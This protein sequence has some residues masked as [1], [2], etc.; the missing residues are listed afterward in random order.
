LRICDFGSARIVANRDTGRCSDECGISP[1]FSP[2]E[3]V[4][5]LAGLQ[6]HGS[7]GESFNTYS[8][9]RA[10]NSV[11]LSS[12]YNE[13]IRNT[14]TTNGDSMD[15]HHYD[16]HAY[17]GYAF[18]MYSLGMIMWQSWYQQDPE[19]NTPPAASMISPSSSSSASLLSASQN[20]MKDDDENVTFDEID[21]FKPIPPHSFH[22]SR[23]TTDDAQELL[24]KT[25]AGYRPSFYVSKCPFQTMPPALVSLVKSLWSEDPK[26]RPSSSKVRDLLNSKEIGSE[27]QAAQRLWEKEGQHL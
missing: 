22:K 23:H 24:K 10:T 9:S 6:N 4:K 8:L 13:S 5:L 1:I 20:E 11:D 14:S 17:N 25:V 16:A 19:L 18:D 2:P 15:H 21:P 12:T 26:L 3:V 7:T 27:I